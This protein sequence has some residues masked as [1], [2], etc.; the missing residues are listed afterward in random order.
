MAIG[1]GRSGGFDSG[2]LASVRWD[3]FSAPATTARRGVTSKP[4]FDYT[5]LGLL[6]PQNDATEIIYI[7]AQMQHKKQLGSDIHLHCHYI[8]AGA[9]QPTFKAAYRYYNNGAAVPGSWTIV[10]TA[11]AEGSKGVFDYPGSR[12]IMQIATFPPIEAPTGETVSA[13]IDIKFY[14]EDNDVTGD[15]LVKYIDYHFQI[16]SDGSPQEF[17]K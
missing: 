10:S 12:S 11:D 7:V 14:R 15:V 8:Q 13:N 16:D 1:D 5:E 6:F 17:S 4:D 3:D 2:R 9:D